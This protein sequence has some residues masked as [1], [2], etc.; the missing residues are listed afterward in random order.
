MSDEIV[1]M[2][3]MDKKIQDILRRVTTQENMIVH[4]FQIIDRLLSIIE[5]VTKTLYG[6]KE[7]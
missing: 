3:T 6:T 7:E 5:K 1:D 4:Q 2:Y